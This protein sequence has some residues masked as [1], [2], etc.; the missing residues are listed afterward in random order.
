[1]IL[2]ISIKKIIINWKQNIKKYVISSLK[3]KMVIYFYVKNIMMNMMTGIT[4][5]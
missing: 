2:Q 5:Q 1:M 3:L 4:A